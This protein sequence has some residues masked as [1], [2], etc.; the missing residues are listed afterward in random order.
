MDKEDE[1]C[2]LADENGNGYRGDGWG[3]FP[4]RKTFDRLVSKQTSW[5]TERP[6]VFFFLSLF[7]LL[8]RHKLKSN[9]LT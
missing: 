9:R 8:L 1:V 5:G 3:G 4:F 6:F 2:V 7:S